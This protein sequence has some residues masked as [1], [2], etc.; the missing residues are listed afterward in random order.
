LLVKVLSSV[1]YAQGHLFYQRDGTLMAHPFDAG[2]GR[3]SG[4][5]FPVADQVLYNASNG[6]AA[7]SVSESG[8]LAYVGGTGFTAAEGRTLLLLDRNGASLRTLGPA[9]YNLAILSPDGRQ[10]VVSQEDGQS[11]DRRLYLVDLD[12][13]VSTRFTVG[14]VDER[15]PV[16]A[17]DSSSIAFYSRRDKASGI[18][19]RGAGGGATTDELLWETNELI[20]PTGFSR[21]G[22]RLLFTRGAGPNQRI[23]MLPTAG[24]RTPTQVFPGSTVTQLWAT[25]SPDGKWIVYQEGPTPAPANNQIYV[26]AYPPDGRRV[27]ISMGGGRQPL[28]SHDGRQIMYRAVDDSIVTVPVSSEGGTIRPSTPRPVFSKPLPGNVFFSYTGDARAERLLMIRPP[29]KPTDD[30][31]TITVILNFAQSVLK[32]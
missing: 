11:L 21:D 19:R 14:N 23:W 26:Q 13:G 24:D 32:K 16:W 10:A 27:Q 29:D 2:T 28:W 25:F 6:R 1:E 18:Y 15:N 30:A 7:M 31:S 4:E 12:R 20:T 3:L 8:T 5:E 17:P 22:Q 9:R